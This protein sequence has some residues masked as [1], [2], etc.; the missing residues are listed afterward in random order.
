[1]AFITEDRRGNGIFSIQDIM[2]NITIANI[3]KYK[4]KAGL[5]NLKSMASDSEEYIKSVQ[6][7]TP[8]QR[9]LIKNLSGGNQ[10]KVLVARWLLTQ[11]DV[12]IMDEPTRGIDVGSKSEI[13]RMI[14]T[15]AGQGKSIIMISSELPE[16]IGMSDRIMVMHEGQITGI[17]ENDDAITQ[18]LLL[19]YASGV[20]DAYSNKEKM[21]DGVEL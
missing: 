14:S 4:N 1:L 15:L 16:I 18:E 17:I 6:I 12:I 21:N 20:R 10:Q 8:S 2:F 3:T 11:P 13:H 7:K 5:L 9:Q 19:E